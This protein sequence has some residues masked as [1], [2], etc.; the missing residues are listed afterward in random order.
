MKQLLF[1]TLLLVIL[2]PLSSQEFEGVIK[3]R[4]SIE[5][6]KNRTVSTEVYQKFQDEYGTEQVLSY[7]NGNYRIETNN[8]EKTIEIFK[9]DES[10]LLNA[11]G[12]DKHYIIFDP[13]DEEQELNFESPV[14][15]KVK[16]QGKKCKGHHF[17]CSDRNILV[18]YDSN[19]EIDAQKFASHRR[20]FL[21]EI[22]AW[23]NSF[24]VKWEVEYQDGMTVHLEAVVIHK[25]KINEG[26]FELS[27]KFV[28]Q[29]EKLIRPQEEAVKEELEET[30]VEVSKA[31]DILETEE[32]ISE[33]KEATVE[34]ISR[35][36]NSNEVEFS[37]FSL[38]MVKIRDHFSVEL[39]AFLEEDESKRNALSNVFENPEYGMTVEV[40]QESRDFL[41]RIGFTDYNFDDHLMFTQDRIRRYLLDVEV[42]HRD[43]IVING[44]R[45]RP[46]HISG[47]YN[48]GTRV[49]FNVGL[50]ESDSHF[51]QVN[52]ISTEDRF[53]ESRDLLEKIAVSLSELRQ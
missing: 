48:D 39:P 4:V 11:S 22:I 21:S 53:E 41:H 37:A 10:L 35:E 27:E 36:R 23:G 29:G 44:I 14:K 24:P 32:A 7:S 51:Y 33:L 6:P 12:R 42:I 19:I 43:E 46:M 8:A 2:T 28:K 1:V 25:K 18:Y 49:H 16:V 52:V 34:P 31:S 15:K 9:A 45:L 5:A 20:D 30:F 38:E 3:F 17:F 47:D 50:Y 13:R 40:V 26:T